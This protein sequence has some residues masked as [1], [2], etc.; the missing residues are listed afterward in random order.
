MRSWS[1]CGIVLTIGCGNAEV[2]TDADGD[3]F[4]RDDPNPARRDCADDARLGGT[5]VYPGAPERCDGIDNDCDGLIDED[6]AEGSVEY[7][8]D[9][10]GDGFGIAS[11]TTRFA[12]TAP[13]GWSPNRRDCNDNDALIFPGAAERCN[14]LDDDCDLEIDEGIDKSLSWFADLDGD[15][16]GGE[17]V[18]DGCPTSPDLVRNSDDCNDISRSVRPGAPERCDGIDNDCDGLVD[19]QDDDVVGARRFWADDDGDGYG[20]ILEPVNACVRP[21]GTVDNALDCDDDNPAQSPD[22]VWYRDA[23]FDGFGRPGVTF[24]RRQCNQPIGYVIDPGDCD[25]TDG[26]AWDTRRWFADADGDGF[27]YPVPVATGCNPDPLWVGNGDDCDD[28]DPA[29]R[30]GAEEVCDR[31]DNDCDGATDDD[32]DFVLG[33]RLFY[34]D[35]DGDGF[36]VFYDRV[37][38]C[39][40]PPGYVEPRGDC[41]DANPG[42]GADPIWYVD[43]DRD[44][45]GDPAFPGPQGC[46]PIPGRAPNA[47]DCD[48]SDFFVNPDQP[49]FLDVDG[50]G[51]GF[52]FVPDAT[53]CT[54]LPGFSFEGGDCNDDDSRDN[55]GG[56]FGAPFGLIEADLSLDRDAAGVRLRVQCLGVTAP[57]LDRT[58]TASDSEQTIVI[59]AEARSDLPCTAFVTVPD[60]TSGDGGPGLVLRTCGEQFGRPT[61]FNTTGQLGPFE[62]N[63]CSGCTDPFAR[64]YDPTVLV[65][66]DVCY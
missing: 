27:G 35:G 17:L 56:C 26:N 39:F 57:V 4:F 21:A 28:R 50:D 6:D 16:F 44:G 31:V 60:D 8:P 40:A 7:W 38:A 47:L 37:R 59:T 64:N 62:V 51:V 54:L 53:G 32:D 45:Y 52:G 48:D 61:A 18:S 34:A 42:I 2:L 5:A 58:F 29:V 1:L 19:D 63:R 24:P 36:G 46:E 43:A 15:G 20:N 33:R 30:P 41:D 49:Q 23:D 14:D 11:D 65:S 9:L 12:C 25:D 55:A 66:T 13:D 3:G 10:D 22:T